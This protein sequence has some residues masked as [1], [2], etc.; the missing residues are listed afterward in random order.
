MPMQLITHHRIFQCEW[1]DHRLHRNAIAGSLIRDL[2]HLVGSTR[3]LVTFGGV[4]YC[5]R[6][7]FPSMLIPTWRVSILMAR[8]YK[9]FPDQTNS[10]AM[11]HNSLGFTE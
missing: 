8:D 5:C 10:L 7:V 9:T 2:S 3:V 1:P 6:H 4:S 11:R